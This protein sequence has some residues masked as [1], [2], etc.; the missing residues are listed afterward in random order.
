MPAMAAPEDYKPRGG[1]P[2]VTVE[3]TGCGLRF[4]SG[5]KSHT[6]CPEC[7]R[8]L[9]VHRSARVRTPIVRTPPPENTTPASVRREAAVPTSAP[10]LLPARSSVGGDDDE[11]YIHDEHG[12]LV[13]AEW[14]FDGRLVAAVPVPVDYATELAARSWVLE[15]HGAALCQLVQLR[16]PGWAFGAR[17]LPCLRRASRFIPGGG[18]ICDSCFNALAAPP[19]G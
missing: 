19:G 4:P 15:P 16:P 3:C 1:N 6:R 9:R 12:N 14:T 18:V 8:N 13:L 5:A 11:T 7:G 10:V 17:P 2:L